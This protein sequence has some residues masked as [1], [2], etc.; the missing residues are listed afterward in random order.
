MLLVGCLALVACSTTY[1]KMNV[2]TG[3][4]EAVAVTNDV[5]RISARGNEFTDQTTIQDYVLL[6]AAEATL[7]AGKTHFTV[8]GN[9]DASSRTIGQTAGTF[10]SY[11]SFATY[12][13]GYTYEMIQPG[14]DLQV[15]VWSP[16]AREAV[17]PNTFPAQEVFDN[18]NPRVKRSK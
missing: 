3:G 6:K 17:P 10:S 15:R 4:V 2:W 5:Y 13:P 14:Q 8:L 1:G 11:G 12:N 7:G 16:T 18:I 9:N